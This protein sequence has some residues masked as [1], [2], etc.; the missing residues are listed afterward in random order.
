MN[1]DKYI[2][3]FCPGSSGRLIHTILYNLIT[4]SKDVLEFN[5]NN[6]S[7][8]DIKESAMSI[9]AHSPGVYRDVE[10]DESA[11]V[12]VLKTHTFPDFEVIEK[13]FGSDIGIIIITL[14]PRDL[15]EVVFNSH[16]KNDNTIL[17]NSRLL[18]ICKFKKY[19][20]N[21]FINPNLENYP[22]MLVLE[23]N[24]LFDEGPNGFE[25]I[26]K[27]SDFVGINPAPNISKTFKNYA[28]GRLRLIDTHMPWLSE[29]KQNLDK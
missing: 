18:N 26:K 5:S 22:N 10:F 25:T 9:N 16:L 23:Y 4:G 3:S 2:I 27:L 15:I 19:S 24:K 14:S 29:L 17:S 12:K 21:K 1:F 6:D 8:L 7:H 11:I 20:W 28:N 13:K